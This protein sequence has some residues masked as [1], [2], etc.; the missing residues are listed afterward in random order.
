MSVYFPPRPPDSGPL[1]IAKQ[2]KRP[3]AVLRCAPAAGYKARGAAPARASGKSLAI[4]AARGGRQLQGEE[5][6]TTTHDFEPAHRRSATA[7]VIDNLELHGYQPSGNEPDPRPLPEPD[8]VAGAISDLFDILAGAFRDT[9]L[10]PDLD[11]LFWHLT[12]L[13][14]KKAA[15]AQR[16]LDGNEDR[17]RKSQD[18]QDGSEVRSVELESL[19]AQGQSLIERREA[20][21]HIRDLAAERY[22]AETGSAWRP[23][24]GSLVNHR[25]MTAAMIDSRDF[26]AARR[27]AD[28]ELLLPKGPKIAFSGGADYADAKLIW[29]VLDK[30]LAK[31]PDMVLIHGG[32]PKGA[33]KAAACW[34]DHRKVTQIAFKPD[35]AADGKAAPFKRNDR[36]LEIV[37]AGVIVFP[38]SGI[39]GNLADKAKRLGI[40]VLDHRESL[41]RT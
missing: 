19:I 21:E 4:K 30:V 13:F 9:S 25:H 37:P 26:I 11:E 18:E 12:D 15:R 27:R 29:A 33:E 2:N 35:W 7:R 14:H 32:T 22:E 5:T 38:G 20:F 34:A 24:A 6:M 40:P 3:L 8:L 36:M 16:Q 1:C 17:Q 41:P 10:E 23:R 39:T 28:T 31:H